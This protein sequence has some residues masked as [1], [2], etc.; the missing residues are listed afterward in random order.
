VIPNT[1]KFELLKPPL[2]RSDALN[3][4]VKVGLVGTA[5]FNMSPGMQ[6]PTIKIID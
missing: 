4:I 1:A 6:I 3:G 2:D 5:L